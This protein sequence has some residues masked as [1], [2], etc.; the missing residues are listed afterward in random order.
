L[1]MCQDGCRTNLLHSP[2]ALILKGIRY[3][4]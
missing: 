3:L 1:F 4:L 2:T